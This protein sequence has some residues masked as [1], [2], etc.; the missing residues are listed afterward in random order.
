MTSSQFNILEIFCPTQY[1]REMKLMSENKQ[2]AY[3]TTADCAFKI[4]N[5]EEIWLRN[6][7]T[8]NDYSEISYGIKLFKSSLDSQAGQ[9]FIVALNSIKSDLFEQ[10]MNWY[11]QWETVVLNDTFIAC[12]SLHCPSEDHHGRLSMWRAYGDVALVVNNSNF[13]GNENDLG[14]YSLTVNYWGQKEFER[15]LLR[16]ANLIFKNKERLAKEEDLLHN[17]IYNLLIQTAIGTKHPGFA[18]EKELRIYTIPSHFKTETNRVKK[19]VESIH[20]IPQEIVILPLIDYS[21]DGPNLEFPS[22]LSRIIIG[23]TSYPFSMHKA[24]YEL[25]KE[26]NVAE[27]LEKI[28]VSKIP[29]RKTTK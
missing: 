24:F 5:N 3:Y 2:F 17:G 16:V 20:G 19:K 8:M 11:D 21:P 9:N 25:L 29:L 22:I 27:P 15:E 28:S 7:L 10:T 14:I 12:L 1:E 18:E 6:A 23:P 4:I 26:N 13:T